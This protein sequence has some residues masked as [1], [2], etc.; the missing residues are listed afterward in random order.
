MLPQGGSAVPV[1]PAGRADTLVPYDLVL[2]TEAVPTAPEAPEATSTVGFDSAGHPTL[3]YARQDY[4]PLP[5][6][7]VVLSAVLGAVLGGGAGRCCLRCLQ[8]AGGVA[9]QVSATE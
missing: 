3:P 2:A 4:L 9:G 5:V 7:A 8:R 6:V 1:T